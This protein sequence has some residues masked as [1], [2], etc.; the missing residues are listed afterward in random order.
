MNKSII[1]GAIFSV[2]TLVAFINPFD[3]QEK[4]VMILHGVMTFMDQV[5]Y[6]P[7]EMNDELSEMIFD[8]YIDAMDGRKRFLT[9]EEVDQMAAHKLE[10]DNQVKLKTFELFEL[11]NTLMEAAV[12]RAKKIYESID[13]TALEINGNNTINLDYKTTDRPQNEAALK[14]TWENMIKYD[15]ISRVETM[16]DKQE[17]KMK[18]AEDEKDDDS[19]DLSQDD[20]EEEYKPMNRE[21]MISK[22]I[23]DMEESYEKWFK[24][25]EQQRRSDRFESY[26]NAVTHQSDPHTTYFNPKKKEDFDINMGGKLEGIGARLQTDDDYTKV[27]SIVP[28]GPAWKTKLIDPDDLILAVQQEDEDEPLS[29]S[30]MRIDDVVSKIRGKKGTIVKLTIRKADGS[31]KVIAIERDEVIMDESFARSLIVSQTDKIDNIGYIKLPKFYSSFEKEGGNSCAKDIATE[32]EKLKNNKVNGI[33]LDLR[34]NTGGS[35]NDVVEMSGLFIEEGPIVQ[36][37]PRD[38]PAYVHRDK[39]D[40]VLYDGPLIVLVNGYSASASEILAAALQDYKRAVIVGSKSTYGKGTVQRFYDLD[41]AFKGNDDLKP[42]GSLKM[43]MQK[44]F[45]VNGGSTQLK[46]VIPDVILPDNYHY[47]DIG[48]KEYEHPLAWS[49]IE[50]VEYSQEVALLGHIDEMAAASKERI[51]KNQKFIDVLSN[52]K[53]LKEN[54]DQVVYPLNLDGFIAEMDKREAASEKYKDLYKT[55]IASLHY[56]NMPEDIEAINADESKA[57]RN[58]DW[59]EGLQKDFYIEEALSIMKDMIFL[60]DSFAAVEAKIESN[61]K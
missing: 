44:F 16:L 13:I 20:E 10:I 14:T 23:E 31:E 61:G 57:A 36:V 54:K 34:N 1:I 47:L 52:A 45:R 50:P 43:T 40:S 27:I 15:L 6:Q 8:E 48:E 42:L 56:S 55:D 3:Y 51:A 49:E 11:S 19:A 12:T 18:G 32:I 59:I 58:T 46:G 37:K 60:E 4:E 25:L 22:A 2:V 38:R 7:Q 53:R 9:Q 41:R 30:G 5:H 17:K 28:G 35:L 29:L 24:R 33:I 39:D 26:L 21:E